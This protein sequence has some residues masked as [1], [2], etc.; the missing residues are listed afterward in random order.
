MEAADKTFIVPKLTRAMFFEFLS[1]RGKLRGTARACNIPKHRETFVKF[2][3]RWYFGQVLRMILRTKES[4]PV[5]L[6]YL[7]AILIL[8]FSS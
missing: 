5:G 2:G 3:L 6:R 7:H 4:F 8:P 1:I